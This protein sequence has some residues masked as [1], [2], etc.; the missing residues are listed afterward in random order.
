[1][2]SFDEDANERSG[3][4]WKVPWLNVVSMASDGIWIIEDEQNSK[5]MLLIEYR[6][7][8]YLSP[9]SKTIT[10]K[11]VYK[12]HKKWMDGSNSF[13]DDDIGPFSK[14]NEPRKSNYPSYKAEFDY[15]REKVM[16]T[17]NK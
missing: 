16:L 2:Q 12:V 11:E 5:H 8:F 6:D 13:S 14:L 1:M 9:L 15:S 17:M 4:D 10:L 7:T 3:E